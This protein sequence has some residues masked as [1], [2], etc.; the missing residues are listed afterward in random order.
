MIYGRFGD[1]VTIVR[2]GTLEDVKLLD[3]RQPDVVD[4]D[5][6]RNSSYVVV[7]QDD[8]EERLYLLGYLK[9]DNGIAEIQD[10]LEKVCGD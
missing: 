2:R 1:V 5:C 9:A 8:G 4:R 6:V 7:K 10:A 3:N